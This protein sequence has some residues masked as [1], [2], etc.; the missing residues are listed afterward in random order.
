MI[1]FLLLNIIKLVFVM[2]NES[3]FN[4]NQFDI[5][6]SSLLTFTNSWFIFACLKNRFVSSAN[7]INSDN[8]DMLAMSLINIMNSRGL[9]M[10]PWGTQHATG[11]I[12]ELTLFIETYCFR[13][14][15]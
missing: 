10:E 15:K 12:F 13:L 4:W 14:N 8:F 7:M 11:S 9:N 5:L 6:W 1:L 3:L 2:F